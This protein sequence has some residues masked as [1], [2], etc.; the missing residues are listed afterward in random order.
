MVF[1]KRNSTIYWDEQERRTDEVAAAVV[2]EQL[3]I[4]LLYLS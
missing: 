1:L 2:W 4:A 3:F